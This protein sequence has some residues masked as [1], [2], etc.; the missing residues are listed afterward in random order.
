MSLAVYTLVCLGASLTTVGVVQMLRTLQAANRLLLWAAIAIAGT[1]LLLSGILR[2]L[3]G[4]NGDK[5]SVNPSNAPTK[6][7]SRFH[8][9]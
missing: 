9:K 4:R 6:T 3:S 8:R 1:Y 7:D 2:L 5:R